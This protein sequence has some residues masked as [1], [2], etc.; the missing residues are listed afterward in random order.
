MSTP[1]EKRYFYF[2]ICIKAF[3]SKGHGQTQHSTGM[4][5][6][7]LSQLGLLCNLVVL[8][9]QLKVTRFETG[10]DTMWNT[11]GQL[12]LHHEVHPTMAGPLG[13]VSAVVR[14]ILWQIMVSDL[15]VNV[16]FPSQN[17]DTCWI[18]Q[19]NRIINLPSASASLDCCCYQSPLKLHG[20]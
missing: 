6:F 4:S 7:L 8:Q 3:Y 10:E 1:V 18:D 16:F 9:I 12:Q 13:E 15:K 5:G 14:R 20:Y 2:P 17:V 11:T 19:Y